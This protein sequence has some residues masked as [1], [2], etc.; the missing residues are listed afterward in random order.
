LAPENTLPAFELALAAQADLVELDFRETKDG[1]LVAFH[2][3]Q[4][5]RTT[6]ARRRW[7]RRRVRLEARSL[8]E[9]RSLDAGS[10]FDVR[11]AQAQVPLL[12][13]AVSVIRRW[14]VPLLE[15]KAGS[16]AA[17]ASF[18]RER[19]LVNRVV[20]QC[21]DWEWLRALHE[22]EP[23]QVLA[24]LGPASVLATGRKPLGIVRKLNRPWLEQAGQTGA[25]IVVWSRY[26]SKPAIRQAHARGMQVWVYTINQARL[27]TRLVAAGVDGLICND[28]LLIRKALNQQLLPGVAPDAPQSP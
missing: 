22:L 19:E 6:D 8:A 16:A 14:S 20:V 17:F 24:A 5:D 23:R 3:A 27:A 18:L 12:E 4:L 15:R 2:D 7:R 10:W 25:Q 13:E 21:F 11:F 28:P 9:I 26:L 1:H